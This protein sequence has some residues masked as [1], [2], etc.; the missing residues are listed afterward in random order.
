MPIDVKNFV[1]PE[2]DTGGIDK[3]AAL[4]E[5]RQ[6]RQQEQQKQN[7]LFNLR[8]INTLT[9]FDQYKTGQ[10][11]L[12]AYTHKEL[13]NIS[14]KAMTNYV[15]L[16]P[17]EMEFR[18]KNDMQDFINW[19]TAAQGKAD[20][21]KQQLQDFNKTYPNVDYEKAQQMAY[22]NMAND[23]VDPQTGQRKDPSMINMSKSY[24]SDLHDPEVLTQITND[25]SPL[26]KYYSTATKQPFHNSDFT[27]IKGVKNREK[28]SGVFDPSKEEVVPDQNGNPTLDVKNEIVPAVT[29]NGQPLK[30]ID[31]NQYQNIVN[32]PPVFAAALKK[33]AL[34]PSPEGKTAV[35]INY[36]KN[37]NGQPMDDTYK[38]IAFRHWLYND[39]KNNLDTYISQDAATVVPKVSVNVGGNSKGEPT[40]NDVF[41]QLKQNYEAAKNNGLSYASGNN[42]DFDAGNGLLNTIN[43]N[44]QNKLS[45]DDIKIRM[46]DDNK[47]EVYYS[48]KYLGDNPD[49]KDPLL[50]KFSEKTVNYPSQYNVKTKSEVLKRA[51]ENQP[52]QKPKKDPLGLF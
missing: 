5:R 29:K 22:T 19:H 40:I 18:V 43:K 17:S 2:L 34:D 32:N 47:L 30:I 35:A 49:T 27:S 10:G 12:D 51:N 52:I 50:G 7:R 31:T 20:Q 38:D 13:N 15:N 36:A 9:D 11:A 23:F 1:I 24:V 14:N 44:R 25:I 28:Y 6:E 33:W 37:N 39:T 45:Q 46:G 21:I 16:D 41:G 48:D 42:I 8:E 4:N 3:I 26:Q